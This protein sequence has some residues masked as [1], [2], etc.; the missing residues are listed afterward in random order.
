[1]ETQP[2]HI[3]HASLLVSEQISASSLRLRSARQA[4]SSASD[5]GGS[6]LDELGVTSVDGRALDGATGVV[7]VDADVRDVD[8]AGLMGA[9]GPRIVADDRASNR[10][11][12]AAFASA[13]AAASLT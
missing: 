7:G 3:M 10:G 2:E 8:A 11:S 9:T 6:S 4:S 1:M 5:L 12:A 13:K